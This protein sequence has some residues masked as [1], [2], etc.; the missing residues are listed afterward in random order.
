ML[1]DDFEGRVNQ[2]DVVLTIADVNLL[3]VSQTVAVEAIRLDNL[4]ARGEPV[5][6]DA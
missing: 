3:N 4:I 2:N 5:L 6:A 1:R